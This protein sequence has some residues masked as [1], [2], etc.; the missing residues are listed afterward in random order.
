M[1]ASMNLLP[2]AIADLF[3]QA[4][5]SGVITVADRYALM[6][7]LLQDTL[8]DEERYAIDRLLHAVYKKR[9]RIVDELSAVRVTW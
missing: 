5:I 9:L 2:C 8:N 4:S 6:A 3:A 7:A 1:P